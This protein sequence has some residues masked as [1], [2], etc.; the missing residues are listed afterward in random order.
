M[1][2][3]GWVCGGQ[4]QLS[5]QSAEAAQAPGREKHL[6]LPCFYGEKVIST[7]HEHG[8]AG[9]TQSRILDTELVSSIDYSMYLRECQEGTF[10]AV[11]PLAQ[12]PS[13]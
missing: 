5:R 4:D 13:S 12:T 3:S 8:C 11:L 6:N 1:K 2:A 9:S 10:R 7:E